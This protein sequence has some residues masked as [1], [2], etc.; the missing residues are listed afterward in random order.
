MSVAIEMILEYP[1]QPFKWLL[2]ILMAYPLAMEKGANKNDAGTKYK[3]MRQCRL[4]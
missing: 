3:N 1:K 4:L 2:F